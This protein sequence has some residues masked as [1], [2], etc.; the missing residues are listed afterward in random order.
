LLRE[1]GTDFP[2][3][4]GASAGLSGRVRKSWLDW[5]QYKP[6]IDALFQA[7]LAFRRSSVAQISGVDTPASLLKPAIYNAESLDKPL[8]NIPVEIVLFAFRVW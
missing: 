3:R 1:K 8:L 6:S 5:Q 2:A 4:V 7:L